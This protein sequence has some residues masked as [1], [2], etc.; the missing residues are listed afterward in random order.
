[1]GGRPTLDDTR[2]VTNFCLPTGAPIAMESISLVYFRDAQVVATLREI[3]FTMLLPL[4]GGTDCGAL[5]CTAVVET[6]GGAF[7]CLT[8]A[9]TSREDQSHLGTVLVPTNSV[10]AILQATE[11]KTL[12]FATRKRSEP[13]K[14]S[15]P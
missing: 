2:R 13:G 4:P 10:L 6:M 5:E 3:N 7:L 1:M 15:Q 12:G 11:K 8:P 9:E 14:L